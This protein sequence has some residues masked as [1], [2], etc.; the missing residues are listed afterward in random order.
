MIEK[1]VRVINLSHHL[2]LPQKLTSQA[3][4]VD[5][6]ACFDLN[7]PNQV[8]NNYHSIIYGYD[9][10][11]KDLKFIQKINDPLILNPFCR[12]LIP[13]GLRLGLPLDT[14]FQIYSRSGIST[15]KGILVTNQP[16]KVDQDYTGMV[17]VSITNI[18]L[19]PFTINHG[20]RIAQ[21]SI[22][23]SIDFKWIEVSELQDTDRSSGGF[24]HTGV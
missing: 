8:I 17:F 16:G 6:M 11:N 7:K 24:G 14:R 19:I 4:A 5:L 22:E 1:E 10:Y 15:K 9:V 2:S 12:V 23:Q 20:D 13:T 3:D 18:S 21:G